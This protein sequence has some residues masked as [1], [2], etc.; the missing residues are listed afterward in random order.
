[1]A[2][3][4]IPVTR[5][6]RQW[7]KKV[8]VAHGGGRSEAD[9]AKRRTNTRGGDV[10][11][12][13]S[14]PNIDHKRTH[15]VVG[16]GSSAEINRGRDGRAQTVNSTIRRMQRLNVIKIVG[17]GTHLNHA[18]SVVGSQSLD[19]S[20]SIL[21]PDLN[22]SRTEARNF[23]GETFSVRS[24]RVRLLGKLAHEKSCLLVC[25]SESLHLS[26]LSCAFCCCLRLSR[27]FPVSISHIFIV[28]DI[29]FILL[30]FLALSSDLLGGMS[31]LTWSSR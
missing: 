3:V 24:V 18:I 1:M 27:R 26:S 6:G 11:L 10:I 13:F 17:N 5:T 8:R 19:F 20:P 16:V 21:E 22:L 23:P 29:F 14:W 4:A 30:V 28:N 9:T 25:E 15:H 31:V 12:A 2:R 7:R